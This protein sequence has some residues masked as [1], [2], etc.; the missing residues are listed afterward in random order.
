MHSF[1]LRRRYSAAVSMAVLM[2][3]ATHCRI[4]RESIFARKN[5]FYPDC[6]KNYQISMYDKPLCTDGYLEF[7]LDGELHRVG[8]ERIHLEDDA[9]KL[10]HLEDGGSLVDFNRCGVPLIEIVS[11]P[12]IRSPEEASAYL[13]MLR[14][15]LRYLGICDEPQFIQGSG[16][17]DKVR[18]REA[19]QSA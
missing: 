19:D 12:D 6:P 14:R 8:I 15:T 17:G 18:D 16:D 5:Y 4:E 7:E 3:L 9:G 10:I 11:K 13:S 1:S 2:G